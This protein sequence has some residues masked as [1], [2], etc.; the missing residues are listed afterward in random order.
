MM[1]CVGIV[2]AGV[3]VLM[4]MSANAMPTEAEIAKVRPVIDELT[5]GDRAAMKAGKKTPAQLAETLL[6]Y[7]KDAESEAAKYVLM[8]DAFD[9]YLEHGPLPKARDIANTLMPAHVK[10]CD[11]SVFNERHGCALA[12]KEQWNYAF[13]AFKRCGGRLSEIVDWEKSYPATGVTE[14]T[15]DAVGDFWWSKAEE[16]ADNPKVAA[17]LRVHAAKWLK[18]ALKNGS[19]RG[20]KKTLAERRIAEAEKGSVPPAASVPPSRTP[21]NDAPRAVDALP[22]ENQHRWMSTSKEL[23]T[24]EDFARAS[25]VKVLKPA[26]KPITLNLGKGAKIEFIG[27]PAGEFMMGYPGNSEGNSRWYYHKVKIT[28]PFWLAKYRTTHE[29]WNAYQKV[30]LSKVDNALGGMKCT[31][32][33]TDDAILEF[34]AWMTKRFRSSLPRGYVVRIPTDAEW[35]YVYKGGA[36]DRDLIYARAF[37]HENSVHPFLANPLYNKIAVHFDSDLEPKLKSEKITLKP[38]YPISMPVGTKQPNAWGFYDMLGP[39]GEMLL[40]CF[41]SEKLGRTR[42]WE[43]FLRYDG[44]EIDPLRYNSDSKIPVQFMVRGGLRKDPAPLIFRYS[45]IRYLPSAG[46]GICSRLCIGPNLIKEKGLKERP[47][48]GANGKKS[49]KVFGLD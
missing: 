20:L 46:Y 22:S 28:R 34:C 36:L 6:G 11:L 32:L 9:L 23:E 16:H 17:A 29:M 25:A 19:V 21:R 26:G 47:A 14:L 5:A 3:A 13:M 44:E 15:T 35:E 2:T 24:A 39:G 48:A 49:Y 38:I 31:H 45:T 33:A 41:D 4:A 42:Q 27:C 37:Y 40:D 8:C 18:E 10:G 43:D 7:V 12:A 30:K 1:R